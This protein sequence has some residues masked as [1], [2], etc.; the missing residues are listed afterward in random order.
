MGYVGVLGIRADCVDQ[1]RENLE[2]DENY[3]MKYLMAESMPE[4]EPCLYGT[5][6]NY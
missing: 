3:Q 2:E 4:S 6:T 5:T 1:I